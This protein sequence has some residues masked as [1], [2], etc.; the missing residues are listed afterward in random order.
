MEQ[1]YELSFLIRELSLRHLSFEGTHFCDGA[2]QRRRGGF[3]FVVKGSDQL[4]TSGETIHLSEGSFFFLPRQK[5][6]RSE[7][8]GSPVIEYYMLHFTLAGAPFDFQPGKI[9]KMCGEKTLLRF[10][11][12]EE[13]L[14][15]DSGPRALADAASL[16]A[17]AAE[18]LVP[19]RPCPVHPA[20]EK[21][22]EFLR[23]NLTK[24]F[25]VSEL[26]SACFLSESRLYHLFRE[27]W[28]VSPL[29]LLIEFRV[30]RALELLGEG[31][32]DPARLLSETGFS[33]FSALKKA[34]QKK[35]G[36]TPAEY[37]RAL[38]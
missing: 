18:C 24:D 36:V 22:E 3:G 23:E 28:G 17:D 12:I 20:L 7:W 32:D 26:A 14:R 31:T 15:S 21:A 25:S 10:R 19:A 33:S 13:A 1:K 5:R 34:F 8:F 37:R 6:Y 11:K 38:L 9:E 29:Q 16:L 2:S 35:T 30:E 4:R 27:E